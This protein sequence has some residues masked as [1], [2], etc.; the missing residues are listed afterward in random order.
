M[1]QYETGFIVAPNLPEEEVSAL[2]NQMAEAIASKKG[3]MIKKDIWGKRKLA[4][5]IKK[6]N[7]G[8]YVFFTYEGAPAVPAELERKLK[9]SDLILRFMTIKKDPRG[10]YRTKKKK[11]EKEAE[12]V[13]APAAEAAAESASQ[14]EVK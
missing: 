1:N 4:Y 10:M 3:Q 9:Q 2:I 5:P 13:E 12:Q 7:E 6:F 8:I 14:E 11:K